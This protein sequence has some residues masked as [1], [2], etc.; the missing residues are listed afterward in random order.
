MAFTVPMLTAAP[1]QAA[2]GDPFNSAAATVYVAQGVP[3]GLFATTTNGSGATSFTPVGSASNFQYNAVA[4]NPADNYIY[5]IAL[6]AGTANN[7]TAV[8]AGSLIRIGQDGYITRV[9]TATFGAAT[10]VGAFSPDGFMYVMSGNAGTSIQK[11]NTTTGAPAGT[12]TLTSAPVISDFTYKGGFFWAIQ[13]STGRPVR[14]NPINGAVLVYNPLVPIAI[15][16][17]AAWTY[18]N[19]N[20]GF[21]NNETGR[22]Y[23]IAVTNPTATPPGVPTFTVVSSNPGPPNG[24]N[25]GTSSPGIPTDLSIIK[26]TSPAFT[27]GTAISYTITVTNNG[28]GVSTGFIVTDAVPSPLTTVTTNNSAACTV[29]GNN[30]RCVGGTL[31]VGATQT[32]TITAQVPSGTTACITNTATVLANEADSSDTNNSSSATSCPGPLI[33]CT[34]NPNL[35]NTGYNVATGGVL[36]NLAKDANWDVA[37]PFTTATDAEYTAA[38]YMGSSMPPGGATWTDANVGNLVPQAGGWAPSPYSNAQWISQ[39]TTAAPDQGLFAGDWYYRYNFTLAPSVDAS[40]F[41]LSMDFY[42]DNSVSQIFINGTAQSS[43]ITG[44]PSS[45]T[46]NPYFYPGFVSSARASTTLK[47]NWQTGLNSIIIQIKSGRPMEGFMAQMRPSALCASVQVT[48][49]VASRFESADQFTVSV[50]DSTPTILTSATTSGTGTSA[51]SAL[52]YIRTGS[53]YTLTDAPAAGTDIGNYTKTASCVGAT[54]GTSPPLTGTG[55][56]WTFTPAVVENYTCSIT[57][58][59]MSPSPWTVAKSATVADA[60]PAGGIVH[61]GETITYSVVATNTGNTSLPGV[62]L[63]DDL[64]AVLD[65]AAFVPGSAQLVIDGGAPATLADPDTSTQPITLTTAPFTLPAGKLATLVYRVTSNADAWSRTLTN[66]VTG[67]STVMPP[68]SCF[69]GQEPLDPSCTTTHTTPAKFLIEKVGESSGSIWVP[70][71]GS[72]WAIHDDSNGTPGAVNPDYQAAAVPTETGRFQV[73][74]I[75]PGVYWLEETVAPHGFNLLAEPVQFTVEADGAITVGEGNGS[76]VVTSS[77]EDEDN[78]F[79]VTVR[80]VP[81][82]KM[83]DTGGTSYW[84]FVFS[85]SALLLAAFVLASANIRRRNQ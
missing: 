28:A 31:A 18:G 72:S 62:V 11:I 65:D 1:V 2:P 71:T 84:P 8:P 35:F 3:T 36:A 41:A 19:G 21:S 46:N 42:A 70:M 30:V 61:P 37:G 7:G 44:I 67:T 50:A 64:S 59:A 49:T 40:T 79:L 57:N 78:I 26:T 85:G 6:T 24:N 9:G 32:Y 75:L 76:G 15:G 16:Y 25:D 68:T 47:N 60:V 55:P 17:G 66:V 73:E 33:T 74:G 5:G 29:T 13:N 27:P 22:I 53:T 58:T 69:T 48:K 12:V 38:P 23:Q 4:Y 14:I 54:S 77:D 80:D 45:G 82:L 43:Q 51:T 81:S 34:S 39:Q 63:T 10:N 20:L 52:A 83:P 56:S